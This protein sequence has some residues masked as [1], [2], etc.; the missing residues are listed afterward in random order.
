MFD[1]DA[2]YKLYGIIKEIPID[3]ESLWLA[4]ILIKIGVVLI[5]QGVQI[6]PAANWNDLK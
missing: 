2:C 3:K 6:K 1:V 5:R 4:K